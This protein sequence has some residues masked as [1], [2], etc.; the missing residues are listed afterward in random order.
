MK[1][2]RRWWLL[3]VI[4]IV[5]AAAA[6]GGFLWFGRGKTTSV[7]YL[8]ATAASGTIANTVQADFSLA[9]ASSEMTIALGGDRLVASSSTTGSSNSTSTASDSSSTSARPPRAAARRPRPA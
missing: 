5:I 8:T 6:V 1:K 2:R 4:V 9:D 3:A 7:H